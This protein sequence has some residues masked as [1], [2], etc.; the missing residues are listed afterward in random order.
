VIES[1]PWYGLVEEAKLVSF[2]LIFSVIVSDGS[3]ASFQTPSRLFRLNSC[4]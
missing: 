3:L 2:L 4:V 1:M